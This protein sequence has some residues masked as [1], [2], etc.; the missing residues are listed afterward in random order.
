MCVCYERTGYG[1]E[2]HVWTYDVPHELYL[3]ECM[4]IIPGTVG[5]DD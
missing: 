4:W 3:S 1:Y 5:V 2:I